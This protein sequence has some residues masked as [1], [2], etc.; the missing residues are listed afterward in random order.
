MRRENKL[1]VKNEEILRPK[2]VVR[3]TGLSRVTVW[4]LSK[5]GEFP[6][7]VQLGPRSVGWRR[8]DIDEWMASLQPSNL[9]RVGSSVDS[10]DR[11]KDKC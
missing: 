8:S 11:R 3:V 9:P 1:L 4:R 5:A 2:D 7:S 6:A 10:P